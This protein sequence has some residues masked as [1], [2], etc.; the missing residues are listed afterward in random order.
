MIPRTIHHTRFEDENG[1]RRSVTFGFE[2]NYDG[3][4]GLWTLVRRNVPDY[5]FLFANSNSDLIKLKL[6]L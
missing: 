3:I 1:I 5:V 2:F 4:K 6:K